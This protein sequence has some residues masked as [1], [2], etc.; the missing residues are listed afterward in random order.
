MSR[1]RPSLLLLLCA[2][3][4]GNGKAADLPTKL[5]ESAQLGDCVY[6]VDVRGTERFMSPGYR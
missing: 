4:V 6:V 3:L 5:G 2:L 1:G